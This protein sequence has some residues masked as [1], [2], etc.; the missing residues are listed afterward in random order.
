M[1]IDGAATRQASDICGAA[2]E[3]P[4]AYGSVHGCGWRKPIGTGVGIHRNMQPASPSIG[5]ETFKSI[6]SLNYLSA[7]K[8]DHKTSLTLL[9]PSF[10]NFNI[11]PP[12]HRP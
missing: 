9:A 12:L 5:P 2:H 3:L 4:K 1:C 10:S 6:D 11:R 7:M 8:L